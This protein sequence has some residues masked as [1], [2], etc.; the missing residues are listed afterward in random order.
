[1][2]HLQTD[3]AQVFSRW[4]NDGMTGHRK[5]PRDPNQPHR[6]LMTHSGH[7]QDRN[8]GVQRAA[9]APCVLP[10]R[11]QTGGVASGLT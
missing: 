7:R 6:T 2:S 11:W 3:G 9:R 1:M 4:H 10:V 8:P 5:R